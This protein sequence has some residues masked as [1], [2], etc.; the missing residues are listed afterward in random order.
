MHILGVDDV[1]LSRRRKKQ[2]QRRLQQLQE[3]Q[4]R[5]HPHQLQPEHKDAADDND[6][7]ENSSPACTDQAP[8][9]STPLR[10]LKKRRLDG[11]QHPTLTKIARHLLQASTPHHHHH[12]HRDY[13]HD[14]SDAASFLILPR[15]LLRSPAASTFSIPKL[16]TSSATLPARRGQ[17][18]TLASAPRVRL[19]L[20]RNRAAAKAV[21]GVRALKALRT[22]QRELQRIRHLGTGSDTSTGLPEILA[23][24]TA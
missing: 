24:P 9:T 23:K 12:H 2:Q 3:T 13:H 17:D 21:N 18:P 7:K 20:T 22:R 10:L 15:E 19:P 8:V 1:H 4:P 16:S 14:P 11:K 5:A 6:N